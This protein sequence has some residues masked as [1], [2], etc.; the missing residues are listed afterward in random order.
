MKDFLNDC[1]MSCSDDEI[2]IVI[3]SRQRDAAQ[4]LAAEMNRP[5]FAGGSNS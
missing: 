3:S 1:A 4:F 2:R 5:G